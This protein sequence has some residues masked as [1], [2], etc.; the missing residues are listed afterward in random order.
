MMTRAKAN[1][2]DLILAI[3]LGKEAFAAH[4]Q[5]VGRVYTKERYRRVVLVIDNAA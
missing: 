3:D 5:H 2:T 4:L 1:A